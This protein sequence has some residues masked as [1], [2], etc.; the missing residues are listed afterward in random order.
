MQ[1]NLIPIFISI[2]R[3]TYTQHRPSQ[4]RDFNSR[5]NAAN[6]IAKEVL[7]RSKSD[8]DLSLSQSKSDTEEDSF[9]LHDKH[10][11]GPM[12]KALFHMKKHSKSRGSLN[13]SECSEEPRLQSSPLGDS[14]ASLNSSKSQEVNR[15]K[16][17]LAPAPPP[18]TLST[19]SKNPQSR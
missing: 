17:R 8:I 11:N 14:K 12:K 16:K 2:D 19:N 13:T 3:P 10:S 4:Q 5:I 15:S 1:S 7:Q 6:R 9:E 18:P